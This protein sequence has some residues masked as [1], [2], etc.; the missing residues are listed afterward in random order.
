MVFIDRMNRMTTYYRSLSQ[1]TCKNCLKYGLIRFKCGKYHPSPRESNFTKRST[2]NRRK[3][4]IEIP[5]D[6]ADPLSPLFEAAKI[7]ARDPTTTKKSKV[8]HDRVKNKKIEIPKQAHSK[9]MKDMYTIPKK[10]A[11]CCLAKCANQT[12]SMRKK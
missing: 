12:E 10:Y 3:K 1:Y 6:F 5:F 9:Q 4:L 7:S 11:N 8:F 2:R